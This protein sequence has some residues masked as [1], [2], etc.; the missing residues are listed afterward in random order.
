MSILGFTFFQLLRHLK[1]GVD[2]A[3]CGCVYSLESC[4]GIHRGLVSGHPSDTKICGHSSPL[5]KM[6]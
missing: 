6:A 5:Y 4:L 3:V 2:R 1:D